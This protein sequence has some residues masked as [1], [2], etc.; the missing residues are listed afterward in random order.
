MYWIRHIVETLSA[1]RGWS[2]AS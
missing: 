1:C 2:M